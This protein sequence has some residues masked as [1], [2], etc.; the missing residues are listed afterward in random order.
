[1]KIF[2]K[3]FEKGILKGFLFTHFKQNIRLSEIKRENKINSYNNE[4]YELMAKMR[5]DLDIFS[6]LEVN[7]LMY[8]GYKFLEE[9]FGQEIDK[10]NEIGEKWKFLSIEKYFDKDLKRKFFQ[11][12]ELS[13]GKSIN[14][15]TKKIKK[16]WYC[17]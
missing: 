13:A 5:T 12:L 2:N 17:I 6:E 7:S 16:W 10:N 3:N 8:S 1:M 9:A 15:Y 14:K 11:E 4:F